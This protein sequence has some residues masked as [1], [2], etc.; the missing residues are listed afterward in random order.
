MA[1]INEK[2]Y[3][4]KNTHEEKLKCYDT[5]YGKYIMFEL[6]LSL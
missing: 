6:S 2:Q 1:E 4:S 3:S 5:Y